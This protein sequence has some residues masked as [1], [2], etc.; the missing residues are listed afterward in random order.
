[1][2]TKRTD[3]E[4]RKKIEEINPN[5]IVMDKY[6][7]RNK[8]VK[9]KCS[10]CGTTWFPVPNSLYAGHGCPSC[11]GYKR[12]TKSDLIEEVKVSSPNIEILGDFEGVEK[13]L[14]CKCKVCGDEF[15]IR[16]TVLLRGGGC[17]SCAGNKKKTTK[18]FI[19]ELAA[20][21]PEIEVLG[22][23]KNLNTP[24]KCKCKKCGDVW[25]AIPKN[26]LKGHG[27][28]LCAKNKKGTTE[29]F[30]DRMKILNPS[31]EI[32]GTYINNSTPI[33]CR[34]GNCGNV[35]ENNPQHLLR[36]Q[37]CPRCYHTSTSFMEKFI[38]EA[39]SFVLG[40]NEVICREKITIGTEMDIY[41]PSLN[42][43]IE[44]GSFYWHQYRLEKDYHKQ[45]LAKHK[46]IRL[47][48][49]YDSCKTNINKK[50][51]VWIYTEELGSDITGLQLR[52]LVEKLFVEVGIKRS[53]DEE[54]WNI[55][56]RLAYSKAK[57]KIWCYRYS[58]NI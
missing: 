29:S 30:I 54:E 3:E 24:I 5:I 40:E 14:L 47:I 16:P 58:K 8:K 39:F 18:S 2:P 50:E 17:S 49:I 52:D 7:G 13:K 38:S 26:L 53:L 36:G 56:T 20:Q 51:D 48:I 43:A 11:A 6:E 33:Q 19:V 15:L 31:I 22:E 21:N 32:I 28:A 4:F 27:C 57:R 10:I 37:G 42:F 34:C 46:G 44:P 55:I 41:I 35:W 12:R 1:M 9:C 23:Y 45:M 25:N